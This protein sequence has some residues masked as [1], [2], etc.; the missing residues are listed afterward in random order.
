MRQFL[1]K[2]QAKTLSA[3]AMSLVLG[4]LLGV[5]ATVS[6]QNAWQKELRANTTFPGQAATSATQLADG[7]YV[8][9]GYTVNWYAY[10]LLLVHLSSDGHLLGQKMF[11]GW[12]PDWGTC[13]EATPDGGCIVTGQTTSFGDGGLD[14]WIIK[15]TADG[16]LQ[17]QKTYGGAPEN[18]LYSIRPTSDGGYIAAGDK[19]DSNLVRL[20]GWLMK[21]D[22]QG[23]VLWERLFGGQAQN[24]FYGVQATPDGGFSSSWS[25]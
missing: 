1:D 6:A 10:D 8:T 16:S 13:V 15:L 14:A 19:G 24:A 20:D 21:L 25:G 2:Y 4:S 18:W 7:T 22:S 12:G 3:I 17:W 11:G 23:G 5:S 9:A